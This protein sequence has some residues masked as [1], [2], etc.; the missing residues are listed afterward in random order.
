[1][2]M[3]KDTDNQDEAGMLRLARERF[4]HAI[5]ADDEDREEAKDDLR[6]IKGD[7]WDEAVKAERTGAKRPC[8]VINKLAT[9]LDQIIGDERQ[10]KPRITVLPVDS[11]SDPETAKIITGLIR[12]IENVSDAEVAYDHAFESAASCGRGAFRILTDYE[13]DNSF[14]Q[15]I[16]IKRIANV[17]TVAWGPHNEVD[18]SDA[19]YCF[20]LE[21]ISAEEYKAKFPG[22]TPRDFDDQD[23]DL[24]DWASDDQYTIAEYFYR[25]PKEANLYLLENGEITQD[26]PASDNQIV[27]QR[28]ITTFDV[29]WCKTDGYQLLDKVVS[30]PGKYIP[31]IPVW[32][33]EINIDGKRFTRGAIRNSKDAQRLYN[34]FRST[35]AETIAL[36]P[37]VPYM[38]TPKML[39]NHKSMWDKAQHA[40]LPYLLFN[41]DP[42]LPQSKPFREQPPLVS[43]G[44]I[45][46]I[47]MA[48]DDI[49][50][51]SGYFD[52][53][54]GAK[55]NETSGIAIQ[56]RQREGDVGSFA[57]VDNLSRAMRH[58]GRILVDLIPKI[59]DTARVKRIFNEDETS[60]FV[61]INQPF[62]DEKGQEQLYDLTTGR[63]DV[64]VRT[65]PSYTTQRQEAADSMMAFVKV[66]PNQAPLIADLVVKNMDWPGSE[67]LSNRLRKT[68][69]PELLEPEEGQPEQPAAPEAPPPPPP[70]PIMEIKLA[71]E[72]EKLKQQQA[73]TAKAE[74]ELSIKRLELEDK[75]SQPE[76]EATA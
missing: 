66:I 35:D 39:G 9:I 33:K 56:A 12:N 73:Q 28:K 72:Q 19:P 44:H 59:F 13:D 23:P 45:S 17:F 7:Q 37:R 26:K 4:S 50:A 71:I 49:K 70:D 62:V 68:V 53:S 75:A 48:S 16:F 36:Q 18:G 63:Y 1:M 51:T 67:E 2:I 27:K 42:A 76:E 34:Y 10:N 47:Q 21:K 57:F 22:K 31:V 30:W 38:L 14:N 3:E 60:R 24:S 29:K 43:P 52:A 64:V 41:P 61:A 8:L 46:A 25:Q 15:D 69:P 40:N 74:V 6:F 58:A 65:G 11:E 5:E 32:G 55:S 20:V 54:L